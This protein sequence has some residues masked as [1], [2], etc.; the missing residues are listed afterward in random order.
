M[1]HITTLKGVGKTGTGL[2]KYYKSK[3]RKN[4]TNTLYF[5]QE[6]AQQT[7]K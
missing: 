5:M 1:N 4:F 7:N 2:G 3:D 6:N